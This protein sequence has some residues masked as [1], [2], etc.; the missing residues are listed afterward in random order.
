VER[1]E[2]GWTIYPARAP[3]GTPVHRVPG[4]RFESIKSKLERDKEEKEVSV[5]CLGVFGFVVEV[6][7]NS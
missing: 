6:K 5:W 7:A 1:T 4:L 3:N 2:K